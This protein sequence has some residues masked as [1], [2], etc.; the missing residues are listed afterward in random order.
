[1]FDARPTQKDLWET[2]LPAFETL[3]NGGVETVMGAYNRTL[4][5]PCN[6]SFLLLKKILRETWGF[7]GYVTSDCWAIADFH[8]HH[9][10]TKTPEESAALALKA[11]CDLNCGCT[12][13]MLGL[14]VKE[15]LVTEAEVTQAAERLFTARFKLGL[16]DEERKQW[17]AC[18]KLDRKVVNCDKHHALA[19]EAAQ[20]GVV[21][22]RNENQALPLDGSRKKILLMGPSTANISVLLGNYFGM[23]PRLTT[24]LEGITEKTRDKPAIEIEYRMGALQYE[25]NHKGFK[26]FQGTFKIGDDVDVVIACLGMDGQMEGEEGDAIASDANGDRESIE[27]PPWQMDFLR[28]LRSA[29]TA[30]G[31]K[32]ILVLTGGSPLAFPADIADAILWVWYPGEAGGQAVADVIFGDVNPSGKLPITF[33][34]ATSDLP[35]YEDY[36]MDASENGL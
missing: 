17:A 13:P 3:V 21:L 25:P 15:G 8:E 32:L 20:K 12:Y 18:D 28:N 2:Y 29:T 9:K 6:G 11:G 27:L 36:H 5:E 10:V 35:G 16:F 22:L 24:I 14:A 19:L 30:G 31:K 33:P 4:G 34:A 1:V 26:N 7:D 23:S